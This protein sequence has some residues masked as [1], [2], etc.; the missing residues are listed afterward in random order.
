DSQNPDTG[1]LGAGLPQQG[2]NH[3]DHNHNP[4]H[5]HDPGD[6]DGWMAGNGPGFDAFAL[7]GADG[8][9][10]WTAMTRT[11][12]GLDPQEEVTAE[13]HEQA[14]RLLADISLQTPPPAPP[15]D[16]TLTTEATDWGALMDWDL[17]GEQGL[18]TGVLGAGLPQQGEE[19][20]GQVV[21]VPGMPGPAH[22]P[23]I[24]K[25]ARTIR[26]LAGQRNRVGVHL[27]DLTTHLRGQQEFKHLDLQ[28]YGIRNVLEANGIILKTKL[29]LQFGDKQRGRLGVR[30]EDLGGHGLA[31]LPTIE[32]L[33]RTIRQLAAANSHLG[34]HLADLAARLGL[35]EGVIR[36]V[37]AAHGLTTQKL[38]LRFDGKRLNR[39]GVRVDALGRHGIAE[40]G[41]GELPRGTSDQPS[42]T[43]PQET[44]DPAGPGHTHHPAPRI[45]APGT[46]SDRVFAALNLTEPTAAQGSTDL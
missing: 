28:E 34:V 18:D 42:R 46:T 33:A 7:P 21:G 44:T 25:I 4:D 37:L 3:P 14:Q 12:L 27:A 24:E 26:E 36:G 8:Q 31:H 32:D 23:S 17:S 2:T 35:E 38:K 11:L 45:T 43:A 16:P 22:L 39:L 29:Q 19:P 40:N 9:A 20:R 1:V 15:A 5:D 30:V 6:G 13:H 10:D 41:P